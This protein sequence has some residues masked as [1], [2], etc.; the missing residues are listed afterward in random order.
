MVDPQAKY[1]FLDK[2]VRGAQANIDVRKLI[3]AEEGNLKG[4][5]DTDAD[6]VSHVHVTACVCV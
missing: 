5:D 4:S 6:K 2:R 3:Q 1:V